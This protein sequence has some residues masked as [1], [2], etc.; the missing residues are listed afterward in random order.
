MK[1][2]LELRKEI[3]LA[4]QANEDQDNIH[5]HERRAE[6]WLLKQFLTERKK[7]FVLIFP[8]MR[9]SAATLFKQT[10]KYGRRPHTK[11]AGSL[12]LLFS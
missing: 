8:T 3:T 12:T 5:S 7:N 1:D 4:S 10:S 9:L 6:G 11:K 2:N